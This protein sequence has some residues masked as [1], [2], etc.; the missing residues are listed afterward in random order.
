MSDETKKVAVP[1]Y[2]PKRL[3][4]F[5][6]V[7]GTKQSYVVRDKLLD[8]T[9]DF[10]PWQFFVLEVLP[11]CDNYP[12]LMSVFEDR[13]GQS[14]SIPQLE[15]F[16]ASVA[17]RRLLGDD[18]Q[19]HPLLAPFVKAGQAVSAGK[20]AAPPVANP[21]PATAKPALAAPAAS[22]SAASDA[23]AAAAATAAA[24]TAK[25]GGAGEDLPPGIQ[26]NGNFDP[27]AVRKIWPL[28]DPRPMLRLLMTAVRPL[29][30][31]VYLLPLL[32]LTTVFI[33]VQ[34]GN[35]VWEDINGLARGTTFFE[36]V[37]FSLFTVNLLSTLVT[38]FT[39]HY[40]RATVDAIGIG[41]NLGFLPRFMAR[42]T[43]LKQLTRRERMWLVSAPLLLRMGLLGLGLLTWFNVR[44]GSPTLAS[45][46]LGLALIC[47]IDMLISANPLVKGSAYHLLSGFTNEPHLRGKAYK[48]LLNKW[49]GTVYRQADSNL[50]AAYAL[51]TFIFMFVVILVAML[52]LGIWL[53]QLELGGTAIILVSVLG[54][55]LFS[56]TWTRF[57]EIE[58]A[59]ERS[60]QF[61]R[62]RKR[63][64]PAEATDETLVKTEK[65]SLASFA[66]L[67]I[68]L[69]LLILLFLP[70]PYEPGG[71][72]TVY[73]NQK[74]AVASD[75]PGLVTEVYFDGG[76]T[77]K[78]G[79]VIATLANADFQA[80]LQVYNAKM[81]EQQSVID[82]LKARPKPEEVKVSEAALVTALTQADFS[83]SKLPRIEALF[84]DGAVS[85]EEVETARREAGVDANQVLE[86]QAQLASVK[87]GTTIDHIK[88]EQA[89]WQA[90][91]EER[92]SYA[93]KISRTVLRMP[94]DGNI[95]TLHLKQKINSF[96]DK[97]AAFASVEN[98]EYMSLEV[99]IP[100]SDIRYVALNATARVRPSAY[101]DEDFEGSVTLIDRNVTTRTFGSVVKVLLLVK[102]RDGKL[103]TGMTGYAKITGQSLPVWKAFT[104]AVV[105][106]VTVQV[107]SWIP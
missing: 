29:R 56:R 79:T 13:F 23:M 98:A 28:F 47:G 46:A 59:Y 5:R 99:E 77:V 58:L 11:G 91:K 39:A 83:K 104:L 64:L 57:N 33:A 82:D 20:N 18:A 51:A 107:W 66:K 41:I 65:S 61:D 43:A 15:E 24:T 44:S 26:D 95:L 68:P 84:K 63:A 94:I 73:P 1:A 53:R 48:A 9:H 100:E 14:I 88:A 90:L 81:A 38:A 67:A 55:Y 12:K 49:H 19:S 101:Y 96:L 92:D 105:R 106:F 62:W 40:Y 27:R 37:V 69:S 7:S 45:S 52:L 42:V 70:Y 10:E 21:P 97:G 60:V 31:A 22:A 30:Y 34:Y 87:V 16:F 17:E 2:L 85:F 4:A 25:A 54:I 6:I 102:N 78:K 75:E 93:L 74:Q 36:H 72:F 8:K 103:R 3:E 89:K 35:V 80:Q 32:M 50:L 71:V 76:E 86:K